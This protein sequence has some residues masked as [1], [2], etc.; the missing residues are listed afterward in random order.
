[1]IK[2]TVSGFFS[3]YRNKYKIVIISSF[4]LK[5][6]Q[7]N[8]IFLNRF[9]I[10]ELKKIIFENSF[11]TLKNEILKLKDPQYDMVSLIKS[12]ILLNLKKYST[13]KAEFRFMV[14]M[15]VKWMNKTKV[16]ENNEL[17]DIE[18]TELHM[19][20][21]SKG[22]SFYLVSWIKLNNSFRVLN[23]SNSNLNAECMRILSLTNSEKCWESLCLSNNPICSEEGIIYLTKVFPFLKSL[24]NLELVNIGIN[25]EGCLILAEKIFY[26]FQLDSL[27]LNNNPLRKGA[28]QLLI[29]LSELKYLKRLE[30][31]HCNLEFFNN[32][33]EAILK[34]KCLENL[35][36]SQNNLFKITISKVF[37]FCLPSSTLMILNLE[38]CGLNNEDGRT[39]MECLFSNQSLQTLKMGVNEF[40]GTALFAYVK[41]LLKI[42]TKLNYLNVTYRNCR[43]V[44]TTSNYFG[45]LNKETHD[46][47]L[48]SQLKDKFPHDKRIFYVY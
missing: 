31:K 23:L 7:F 19:Q 13:S 18:K 42:N 4:L 33:L 1:L 46:G 22:R 36:L 24:K 21:L 48:E 44:Q 16:E 2:N 25:S 8:F 14:T 40:K 27:Y 15:I 39:I 38:E 32:G 34:N 20:N 29:A 35:Q 26:L 28:D 47:Q 6:E 45:R 37:R 5:T 17:P 10:K 11:C 43:T 30:L 41:K 3:S 12:E 9:L